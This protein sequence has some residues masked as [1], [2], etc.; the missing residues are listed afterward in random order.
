MKRFVTDCDKDG[1]ISCGD[2]AALHKAGPKLCH[3]IRWTKRTKY[4]REF[5]GCAKASKLAL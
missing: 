3:N 2:F 4:W 5:V 1:L